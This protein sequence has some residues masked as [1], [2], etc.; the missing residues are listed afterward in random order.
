MVSGHF[1][2]RTAGLM[3]IHCVQLG[4]ETVQMGERKPKQM[5]KKKKTRPCFCSNLNT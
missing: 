2:K 4:F 3:M 5:E 1:H